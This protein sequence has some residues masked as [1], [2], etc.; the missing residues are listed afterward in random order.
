MAHSGFMVFRNLWLT[1]SIFFS[2]QSKRHFP[3]S[4]NQ[5]CHKNRR[6]F[7]E[8]NR[9]QAKKLHN[10]RVT[11]YG[12]YHY[13]VI[14]HHRFHHFF[15]LSFSVQYI[16]HMLAFGTA[17]HRPAR[18]MQSLRNHRTHQWSNQ[19]R[20]IDTTRTGNDQENISEWVESQILQI[21]K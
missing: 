11:E 17:I 9:C 19:M 20:Q 7:P 8:R 13:F 10:G 14:D 2:L 3:A 15:I 4:I 6:R 18:W 21:I 16:L 12:K 1:H 5:L